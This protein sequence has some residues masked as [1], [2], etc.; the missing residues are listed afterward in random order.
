MAPEGAR[1][2]SKSPARTAQCRAA[3]LRLIIVPAPC[4]A[5]LTFRSQP[6]DGNGLS[7]SAAC[8][9]G[10][11]SPW[12]P[13]HGHCGLRDGDRADRCGPASAGGPRGGHCRRWPRCRCPA[14][15]RAVCGRRVHAGAWSCG[16][17]DCHPGQQVP[18][19][20]SCPAQPCFCR[21]SCAKPRVAQPPPSCPTTATLRLP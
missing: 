5:T 13:H 12:P 15:H 2:P 20:H 11:C 8:K 3:G 4:I 21:L 7:D 9:V 1:R 6:S 10:R 18:G 17:G 14:A 16:G 19:Q